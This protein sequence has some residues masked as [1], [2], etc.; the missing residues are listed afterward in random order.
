MRRPGRVRM[1]DVAERAGVS[2]KTVSRVVNHSPEVHEETRR[3]VQAVIEELGY[4]PNI[5]ARSLHT[6]RTHT[7]ALVVPDIT[8]P[9]WPEVVHG[10][11]AQ[12]HESDYSVI[13]ANSGES[14]EEELIHVDLFLQRQVD[15]IILCSSRGSLEHLV[16]VAEVV[17]NLVLVNR[18][19]GNV[20]GTGSVRVNNVRGAYLG[21]EYLL[22]QGRRRVAC[23]SGPS[24]WLSSQERHRGYQMALTKSG[25]SLDERLVAWLPPKVLQTEERM[26]EAARLAGMLLEIEPAVD[27]LFVHDDVCAFG[28]LRLCKSES[29]NIPEDIAIVS[30]DDILLAAT[31]DPA[32]TTVA[33]PKQE[34]GAQAMR[35]LKEVMDG[36]T[37]QSAEILIEPHLVIRESA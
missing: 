10:V 19:I 20:P 36:E 13:V 18:S 37:P 27:A 29:L 15:G 7:V 8:D 35:L 31:V 26:E 25:L 4:R 16:H 14:P 30:F 5:A 17:Q 23:L 33:V 34:L 11:Q 2:I 32:L 3:R 9:F 12:A 6:R 22:Q 21:T 1:R 24:H 28:V